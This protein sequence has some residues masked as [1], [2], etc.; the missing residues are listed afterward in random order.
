MLGASRGFMLFELLVVMSILVTCCAIAFISY[1]P[2]KSGSFASD[3]ALISLLF[4]TAATRA[5]CTKTEQELLTN[6]LDSTL[7]FDNQKYQLHEPFH[8]GVLPDVY[9][10]PSA[11]T[12]L[13]TTPISF[14]DK[15][16]RFYKDGT[17][18]SGT[19]YINDSVT[20]YALTVPV[21]AFAHIRAYRYHKKSW[22]QL[23]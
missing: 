3:I 18:Q 6:E 10:P 23:L 20:Q 12:K 16:A 13:I 14:I 8:F 17:M 1:V 19:L 7:T 15:K 9:G 11:P 22:Q 5:V 4:H 21:S 2:L